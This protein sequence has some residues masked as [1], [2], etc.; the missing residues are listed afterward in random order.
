MAIVYHY[1]Q[2]YRAAIFQALTESRR[3]E[4]VFVADTRNMYDS[5]VE[6]WKVPASTPFQQATCRLLPGGFMWQH[7][8]V[9][10]AFR[11]DLQA[12]IF[13]GNAY[14]LATWVAA[15]IAKWQ[16]KRVIFWTQGWR[17]P[18]RGLKGWV[19]RRFYHLA[20][21]L[22]LYGHHAKQIGVDCGFSPERLHVVYNSLNATA[23]RRRILIH[24]CRQ[25]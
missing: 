6:P 4:T 17:K 7:G 14:Y 2:H 23:Q 22:L 12:I 11:R 25:S 9:G 24:C 20:D 1:F 15:W 10:L 13:F 18:E 5:G 8:V 16:G 21:S 3:F 19:R